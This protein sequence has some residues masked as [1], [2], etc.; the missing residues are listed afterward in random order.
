MGVCSAGCAF[1]KL[2]STVYLCF[3][4][5]VPLDEL[6]QSRLSTASTPVEVWTLSRLSRDD[7]ATHMAADASAFRTVQP[8]EYYL[9]FLEQGVR[10]DG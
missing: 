3:D 4:F 6:L 8:L 9:K 2:K 7:A 5:P 10:P 1:E